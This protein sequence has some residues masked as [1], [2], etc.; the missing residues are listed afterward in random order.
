MNEHTTSRPTRD[1]I[2]QTIKR[3]KDPLLKTPPNI[4]P[5]KKPG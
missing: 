3:G 2:G 1:R 4:Y 5:H